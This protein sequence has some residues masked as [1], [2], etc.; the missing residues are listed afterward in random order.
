MLLNSWEK[1]MTKYT[2]NQIQLKSYIEEKNKEHMD[3][4]RANTNPDI[5]YCT[6]P[7]VISFSKLDEL[8]EFGILSIEDFK[9]DELVTFISEM[10]K[11]ATG[12]RVRVDRNEHSLKELEEMADYWSEQSNE[13]FEEEK[14]Q[15]Q[16][17][18]SEFAKRIKFTC[19]LGAKNYRTAIQW[20]LVADNI[21]HDNTYGGGSICYE[22]NLPYRHSKLFRTARVA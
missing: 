17:R 15:E 11:N 7:E 20:I 19:K 14:I 1:T 22:L 12:S 3:M 6:V 9:K 18:V 13:A 10:G 8:A 4:V 2:K 16:K 21:A 5:L